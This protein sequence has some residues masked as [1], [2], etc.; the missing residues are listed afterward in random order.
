MQPPCRL[1]CWAVQLVTYTYDIEFKSTHDHC[2]AD[3]L[4][5]LPLKHTGPGDSPVPSEFNVCQIMSLP[6]ACTDMERA[7]RRDPIIS[8][9]MH[10]TRQGWPQTFSLSL[11]HFSHRRDEFTVEGDCLLWGTRVVIPL[12]L[13]EAVLKELHQGHPGVTRMKAAARSHLWWP[14]LDHDLEKVARSC[15]S[16]LVVK[17]ALHL[18]T[19]GCGTVVPGNVCT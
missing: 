15:L 9:V 6:V 18:C 14:G 5:R 16:C 12:Q 11:K 19:H 3:A 13:Q 4:S 7:S 17:Q 1:Q 10:Y 2:N 8:K